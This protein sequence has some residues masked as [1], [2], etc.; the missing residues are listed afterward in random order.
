[1][2]QGTKLR[3]SWGRGDLLPAVRSVLANTDELFMCVAFTSKAGVSLIKDQ[4]KT[5]SGK[6]LLTTTTFGTTSLEA[7]TLAHELGVEIKILN[8]KNGTYHPKL[9]LSRT[10]NI[11]RAL[12]GSA[13]LT[14]GLISNVE[15][16]VDLDPR[17]DRTTIQDSWELGEEL[18]SSTFAKTWT[19][20]SQ[21]KLHSDESLKVIQMVQKH[22][23]EGQ[24]IETI[25]Q[26]KPNRVTAI[27]DQGVYIETEKSKGLGTSPQ[28]VE[29]WMIEVAYLHLTTHGRLTN[30]YL[31][32]TSGLNV[33]RSSAVCAI[34]AK[35]PGVKVL[36]KAPIELEFGQ[37]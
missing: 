30:S 12:L 5:N 37:A 28:L 9:Y 23:Q 7:L 18:W 11:S 27:T 4:L 19:P 2:T 10:G 20:E 1:M 13:N 3:S 34:L 25:S 32:S 8:P 14:A 15:V 6:R 17:Q 16:A 35:L 33:K 29:S 26:G 22:L 21:L 36:S 24:T 31:L